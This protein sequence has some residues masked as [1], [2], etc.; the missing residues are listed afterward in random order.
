MRSAHWQ[1]P[2]PIVT[3]LVLACAARA[4]AA[5]IVVTPSDTYTKIEGAKAGDTVLIAPGTYKFRVMLQGTG[6]ATSPIV[7]KAQDPNNRPVWDL[8]G[9]AVSAWPGSYTAGDK[10][11]GCWQVKGTHYE[12]SGIIFKN[13]QDVA[14]AGLRAVNAGKVTIRDCVFQN[15]TNGLTG[16]AS[17]L[18]VE[19][20]EFHSN[21]KL[22]STGD[23]THNIYLYGGVFTLRYSYL[24]DPLEGQN[25]HIR[26]RDS[27]IEYNWIARPASYPGDV[28]S[29]EYQCGG[30]GTGAI[31]Q[32][33][34]L[35]GNVLIQGTP[36]NTSQLIAL[37]DDSPGGSVD[38]T[39]MV[40]KME[41]TLINNTVIG[42]VVGSG[43]TQRLVN[44]RNDSV[45]TQVTLHNNIL[46]QVKELAIPYSPSSTN[47][48]VS[49]Q[50]NWVMTGTSTTGLTG[51]LS[52]TAP[53][54]VNET[55]KDFHLTATSPCRNQ[56]A[57]VTGLPTKEYYLDETVKL[58]YR[59]RATA[60]D[61]GAFEHGNSASPVGPYPTTVT[62][63]A[64]PTGDATVK[65]DGKGKTDGATQT[66]GSA[67]SGDGKPAGD[68]SAADGATQGD[69]GGGR[70]DDGCS[71]AMGSPGPTTGLSLLLLVGV[72]ALVRAR[73]RSRRGAA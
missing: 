49:G 70:G 37:Y 45:G 23:P 51:S 18:T 46:Y 13:C 68:G 2:G 47:W 58:R 38:G 10:G 17:D 66:D 24:H 73:R 40:T 25:F 67:S 64:G 31:T 21:G 32:K 19:F 12:I 56:A 4:G 57:T 1:R 50:N 54:F 41:L 60:K 26:A 3:W 59:P 11:R 72:A 62:P 65:T 15:S 28:M 43:K 8:G 6:T 27:T 34:L 35:R 44:M 55:A 69:G 36:A 33:M 16:S 29:C 22:T 48:S 71:C 9:Q 14:S 5:P 61:Q 39:G 63:D 53:G 52:G 7:I 42:A 30:S 20:S